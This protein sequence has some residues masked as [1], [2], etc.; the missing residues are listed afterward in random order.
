MVAAFLGEKLHAAAVILPELED[1][2]GVILER[3]GLVGGA[4]TRDQEHAG[5]DG[6]QEAFSRLQRLR[7]GFLVV[8]VAELG[9]VHRPILR[10]TLAL[11][12]QR[13]AARPG[14]DVAYAV[15]EI[16]YADAIRVQTRPGVHV[17]TAAGDAEERRL[18][19]EAALAV[20]FFVGL[21]PCRHRAGGAELVAHA[22]I[23]D[24]PTLLDEA[25]LERLQVAAEFADPEPRLT[26][27]GLGRD[28]HRHGLAVEGQFLDRG[29]RSE[30]AER[31]SEQSEESAGHG[32][33]YVQRWKR[34]K[35]QM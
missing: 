26:W 18:G 16:K 34:A 25:V 30:G 11:M 14:T 12:R 3:Y 9:L 10:A 29:G 19:G 5:F 23:H 7:L 15:V 22:D 17:E 31:H 6:G 13:D 8:R 4:V 33:I 20:E 24:V 2:R 32:R 35:V 1:V 28:L 21:L 27:G